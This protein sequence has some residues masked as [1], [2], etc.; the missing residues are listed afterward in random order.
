MTQK[1][2]IQGIFIV[3]YSELNVYEIAYYLCLI[4][5]CSYA[6]VCSL[7]SLKLSKCTAWKNKPKMSQST[8]FLKQQRKECFTQALQTDLLSV[9]YLGE[10]QSLC[11]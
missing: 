6:S 11:S 8:C 3:N 5:C 9:P 1:R 4:L 10:E 7:F 2:Q